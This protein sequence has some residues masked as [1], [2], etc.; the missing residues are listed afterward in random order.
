[1]G[2][3]PLYVYILEYEGPFTGMWAENWMLGSLSD[4]Y[5]N[6]PQ[7]CQSL[8]KKAKILGRWAGLD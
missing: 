8:G 2:N 7:N 5:S 6:L 3:C 1:M 4:K